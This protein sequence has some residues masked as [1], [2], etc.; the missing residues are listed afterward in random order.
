MLSPSKSNATC[1]YLRQGSTALDS[2]ALDS[3]AM[4][5]IVSGFR[6]SQRCKARQIVV[7]GG[8]EN[9]ISSDA[10]DRID[11]SSEVADAALIPTLKGY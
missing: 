9:V 3:I 6:D 4:V 5:S 8:H 11:V 2:I 10:T 1:T 7:D